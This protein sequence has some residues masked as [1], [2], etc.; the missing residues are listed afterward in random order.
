MVGYLSGNEKIL[1]NKSWCEIL[2]GEA[3][4]R[5]RKSKQKESDVVVQLDKV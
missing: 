5:E 3:G 4:S 1:L 2:A